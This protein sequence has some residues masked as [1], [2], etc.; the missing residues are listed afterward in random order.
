[1][2]EQFISILSL[3]NKE[4][5]DYGLWWFVSNVDDA[6]QYFGL[7]SSTTPIGSLQGS[8]LYIIV[9]YSLGIKFVDIT[10]PSF[11]GKLSQ[12]SD[13]ETNFIL[14]YDANE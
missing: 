5:L 11:V 3:I 9:N 13:K 10:P 7:T 14:I 12:S 1:M 6:E 8:W 4:G 2:K